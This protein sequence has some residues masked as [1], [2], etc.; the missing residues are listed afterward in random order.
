MTV[1]GSSSYCGNNIVERPNASGQWETCDT[2][3]P[4]CVS[5]NI[6][7]TNP[8]STGP[9]DFMVTNPGANGPISLIGYRLIV[10]DRVPLFTG[11]DIILE[12]SHPIYIEN[13][14]A[15]VTNHSPLIFGTTVS[16][17]VNG[18]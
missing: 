3:A 4:W 16:K 13:K 17:M 6:A 14:I 1:P 15:T 18:M 11:R 10:G 8:G 2:N 12:S 7:S 9:G 5:C